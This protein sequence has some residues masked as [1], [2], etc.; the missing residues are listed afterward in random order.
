MTN[1]SGEIKLTRDRKARAIADSFRSY[2][3]ELENSFESDFGSYQP[4]LGFFDTLQKGKRE[5]FNAQFKKAFEQY[6]NDKMAAWELTASGEIEEAFS[7][8]AQSA[9]QYGAS[10]SQVANSM[11]EKLI[12]QKLHANPNGE[13]EADSPG[14]AKWAMGFFSLASGN[15]AGVVMASAGFDWKNILVNYIAVVGITSFLAIFTG[16]FLGL[17][18]IPLIGLGVG[19]VQVEQ[20][21][22]ELMKATKKEFVKYL[23]QLAQE[24][25][26]PINQ[27]VKDCFDAYEQ[28]VTK[29]INNDIKGR[30]AELNNLLEQKR[31]GDIDRE[32]EVKR[33]Q[34]LDA[35]IASELQNVES[36]Y[37]YLLSSPA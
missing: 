20:A 34:Q 19:S 30:R 17:W 36:G 3:L 32:T 35:Q 33:L 2:I 22:K 8:L 18:S 37:Q 5:E 12:G 4:D 16:V 1:N 9:L 29:R 24:Q 13:P 25:W 26:Q 10:Y 23:P 7:E 27:T 11:T 31:S 28:E 15:V 6:I 21:R 14:W